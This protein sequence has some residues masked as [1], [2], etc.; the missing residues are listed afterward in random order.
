MQALAHPTIGHMDA[1]FLNLLDDIRVKLQ[2][3]FQTRNELTLAISGTGMAGMEACLV[4]LIEPGD[5][6]L[7]CVNG[8]FS[9]R[10]KEVAERMGAAVTA[11]RVP[12]GQ[13]FTAIQV[14]DALTQ[15]GP[16]KLVGLVHVET[17]TGA[18]QPIKEIS[19]VVHAV[20]ALMLVDTVA[21][22]GGV[23]VDVDAWQIDACYSGS[24]K[25]LSCPPGLSLATF[26]TAAVE[27]IERRKVPVGSWYFD[28]TLLRKYWGKERVY[29]HT[30]PVNLYYALDEALTLALEEGLSSRWTR[31]QQAHQQLRTGLQDLGF[32]YLTAPGNTAPTL[33]CVATPSGFDEAAGRLRLINEFGIEV[34][35]GLGEYKGKAWRI[36]LMGEGADSRHVELLLSALKSIL[37]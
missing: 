8:V 5:K 35:A 15:H 18:L 6:V 20:K 16:F 1:Q 14:R 21:S 31:H 7:V 36:G 12:W 3:V 24:Q 27:A 22:L 13:V 37:H 23:E 11:I 26:S 30:P 17:S 10:L 32:K 28:M 34:G 33:N 4:N 29:H 19:E 25:C 2:A 9:A